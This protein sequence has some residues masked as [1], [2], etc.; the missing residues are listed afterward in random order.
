MP[1]NRKGAFLFVSCFL[2]VFVLLLVTKVLGRPGNLHQ[3]IQFALFGEFLCTRFDHHHIPFVHCPIRKLFLNFGIDSYKVTLKNHDDVAYI[4]SGSGYL[5]GPIML[6]VVHYSAFEPLRN[7]GSSQLA[8]CSID[9]GFL[10][11][12]RFHEALARPERSGKYSGS[13]W[14]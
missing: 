7:N 14:R 6:I 9:I 5:C 8:S 13:I 1:E 10:A 12:P 11:F 4:C 2:I 3:R